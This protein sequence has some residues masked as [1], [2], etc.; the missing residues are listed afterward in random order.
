[1]A[2][3]FDRHHERKAE[4]SSFGKNLVRRS[5]SSCEL[6][7]SVNVTLGIYELPPVPKEPDYELCLF[8]CEVCR[9]QLDNPKRLKSD[10]WRCLNNTIWNETAAIQALSLRMLK[11]IAPENSWAEELLEQVFPDPEVEEM[12]D[13]F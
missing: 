4:L 12:A 10:H 7:G 1:M 5:G 3:G 9:D 2:K 6:C 8:I 13:T 11:K